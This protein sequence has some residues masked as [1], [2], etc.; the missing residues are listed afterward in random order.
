MIYLYIRNKYIIISFRNTLQSLLLLLILFACEEESSSSNQ[1]LLFNTSINFDARDKSG[2]SDNFERVFSE[3]NDVNG[4]MLT[5]HPDI[6]IDANDIIW[7]VTTSKT[8]YSNYDNLLDNLNS[9]VTVYFKDDNKQKVFTKTFVLQ[10]SV[11]VEDA[12]MNFESSTTLLPKSPKLFAK[13]LDSSNIAYHL[14]IN[15]SFTIDEELQSS[16]DTKSFSQQITDL[17]NTNHFLF[18]LG[19]D[20][21]IDVSYG[22]CSEMTCPP[23][24]DIGCKISAPEKPQCRYDVSDPIVDEIC[25]GEEQ[26]RDAEETIDDSKSTGYALLDLEMARHFR[27][28]F[29]SDSPKGE[30]YKSYYKKIDY[31]FDGAGF[32]KAVSFS[33]RHDIAQ[34]LYAI[35]DKLLYA[36]HS[37]V[38]ISNELSNKLQDYIADMRTLTTNEEYQDMLDYCLSDL[39]DFT[40]KSKTYIIDKF[41]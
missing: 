19:Q 20:T 39:L 26:N 27:D 16:D 29:L 35:A 10:D 18:T 8:Y 1:V 37:E 12:S 13:Y 4:V 22:E 3:T 40:G 33:Y 15:R 14:I 17:G 24:S 36:P 9:S 28:S 6:G 34:E 30:M 38:I 5:V 25:P 41:Q 23:A 32:F 31:I 21:F 11:L 2:D 7:V